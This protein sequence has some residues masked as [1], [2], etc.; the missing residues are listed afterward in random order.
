H[1]L[2]TGIQAGAFC[3]P[4]SLGQHGRIDIRHRDVRL[5]PACPDDAEGDVARSAGHVEHPPGP[6]SGRIEPGDHRILPQ[7]MHAARH[8]VVHQ[9]VAAGHAVEDLVDHRLLVT[10]TDPAEAE[11]RL[12]AFSGRIASVGHHEYPRTFRYGRTLADRPSP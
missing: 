11:G 8:Q 6:A 10:G 9:V 7:A 4:A 3:A 12:E 5:A 2:D 1:E